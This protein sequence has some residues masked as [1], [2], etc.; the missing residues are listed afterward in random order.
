MAKLEENRGVYWLPGSA[1]E[2]TDGAP[3]NLEFRVARLVVKATTDS[4]T[5]FDA[6]QLE[7]SE[8]TRRLNHNGALEPS[9]KKKKG[10]RNFEEKTTN[11]RISE[12][13]RKTANEW[14]SEPPR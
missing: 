8:E 13:L 10:C 7:E 4:E 5:E 12:P 9:K 1:A 14:T 6:S 11:M 2:S 3:L